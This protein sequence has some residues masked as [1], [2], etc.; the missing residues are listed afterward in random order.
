MRAELVRGC[1]E[2]MTW[3]LRSRSL[4]DRVIGL[5]STGWAQT[6]LAP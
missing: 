6:P 3:G 5:C 4:G 1:V 2:E